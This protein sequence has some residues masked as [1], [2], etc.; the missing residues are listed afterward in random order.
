MTNR[1]AAALHRRMGEEHAEALARDGG[2]VCDRS[3]DRLGTLIPPR[4][5]R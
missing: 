4:M 3:G 5:R 2:K 1:A